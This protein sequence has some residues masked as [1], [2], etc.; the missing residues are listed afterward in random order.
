MTCPHCG[1]E[2]DKLIQQQ[3]GCI[4]S[5]YRI[6]EDDAPDCSVTRVEYREESGTPDT[7]EATETTWYCPNCDKDVEIANAETGARLEV[8]QT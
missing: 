3:T 1:E 7:T 4:N 5:W 6:L 2:I 8:V